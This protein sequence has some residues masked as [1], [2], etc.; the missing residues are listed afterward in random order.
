MIEVVKNTK[1]KKTIIVLGGIFLALIIF[2]LPL[3]LNIYNIKT[4]TYLYKKNGVFNEINEPDALKLTR[5]VIG[6]LKKGE[7]IE[8]FSLKSDFSFF[9]DDEINHLYD[10]RTLIQKI[11]LFLNTSIILFAF[12][13]VLL[14]QKEILI[15]LKN[16]SLIFIFS[17]CIVF[18][19]II[20][21]YFISNNFI[22]AFEKFHELFFPQGNWAFPEGSLLITLLPLNFFYDFL[23][24]LLRNSLIISFIL[25][26]SGLLIFIITKKKIY[27]M[28]R[29]NV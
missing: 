26:L 9:T 23:I 5:G 21:L 12:F 25:L 29:L 18:F 28:Q 2:L 1:L 3:R 19:L 22:F 4:Y 27:N 11:F 15:I 14:L 20:I 8:T 10:V 16:I 17:S 24:L 7:T 13:I 6:L